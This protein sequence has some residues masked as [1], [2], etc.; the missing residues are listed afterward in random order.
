MSQFVRCDE[1][2]CIA[3]F[4]RAGLYYCQNESCLSYCSSFFAEVI[5]KTAKGETK[6]YASYQSAWNK[7]IRLNET[8]VGGTWLFE[9]DQYGWYLH[10][11]TDVK[12]GA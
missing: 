3:G 6:Y 1:C 9:G 7:A 12:A 4:K 8:A 5:L 11:V 2:G 10:F